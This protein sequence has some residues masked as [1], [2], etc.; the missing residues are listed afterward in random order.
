MKTNKSILFLVSLVIVILLASCK[1]DSI[2]PGNYKLQSP[3]VDT[4]HWQNQY[5]NGGTV[6]NGGSTTTP[7]EVA[8]TTWVLTYI[9]IG[10]SNPT[11]PIDTIRFIDNTNYTI[12]GGT[13]KPYQLTAGI[14]VSSKSLTLNYHYPFGSG[15]YTGEVAPT[16]VS[17]G[18]ILNCEFINT[19]TTTTKVRASFKKI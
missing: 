1:K 17:D 10:Y 9:Q 8:G 5:S 14:G 3:P 6:P 4:S 12:N 19:N 15:N 2:T 7:N 11:L 16:F 18:L 13:Y